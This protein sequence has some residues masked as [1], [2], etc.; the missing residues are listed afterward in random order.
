[1]PVCY[2]LGLLSSGSMRTENTD[3][4][5]QARRIIS[6]KFGLETDVR[7]DGG[8][9]CLDIACGL[10]RICSLAPPEQPPDSVVP[11]NIGVHGERGMHTANML[12]RGIWQEG[13]CIGTALGSTLLGS[14]RHPVRVLAGDGTHIWKKLPDITADDYIV[15]RIGTNSFATAAVSTADH[16]WPRHH[17]A[18]SSVPS[19]IDADV[20]YLLGLLSSGSMRVFSE[21]VGSRCTHRQ[22]LLQRLANTCHRPFARHSPDAIPH[23]A[24]LLS[25]LKQEMDLRPRTHGICRWISR[26]LTRI[27]RGRASLCHAHLPLLFAA[28]GDISKYQ[29][30]QLLWDI[31]TGGFVYAKVQSITR[32]HTTM[33]DMHVPDDHTFI[34][35]GFV[36]HNCQGMTLDSAKISL[37]NLFEYGIGYVALSRVRDHRSIELTG[38]DKDKIARASPEALE[39]YG[40]QSNARQ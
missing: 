29:S 27:R 2:L 26:L 3:A 15:Q 35:N 33:Y 13:I 9:F 11:V 17:P 6:D 10:R 23:G 5:L 40:I 34:A 31:Y 1:M 7:L 25:R 12:Y 21:L 37:T 28:V 24:L 8:T 22:F 32:E 4:L 30:M 19:H 20:C 39:F 36:N 18:P 38:Y 14:T 16:A